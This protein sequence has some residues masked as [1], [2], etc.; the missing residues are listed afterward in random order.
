MTAEPN[1]RDLADYAQA[2][3]DSPFEATQARI[4]KRRI[5]ELLDRLKPRRVLEVGCGLDTLARHW[6]GASR[7]TIVEPAPMFAEAA[8]RATAGQAEVEVVEATLEGAGLA[9]EYDVVLLSGLLHEVTDCGGLLD[10]ARGLCATDGLMHA[11]V[12]NA[13]SFHRILALEMGLIDELEAISDR[14]RVLQQTRVFSLDTL[15]ALLG[16]H[17]F[18]P[19][20]R[21]SYFIKPFTH[22]QMARLQDAGI[23]SEQMIEGL[24]RMS[25]WLPE[26]GSEIFINARPQAR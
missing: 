5:L 6:R 20:E 24:D 3:A 17:G 12:P 25:A 11:N 13:R 18:T 23:L 9:G 2:Y 16:E 10:T 1:P 21:G 19:V 8:R 26:Y 4:R 14:Q 15:A 7:F 22:G